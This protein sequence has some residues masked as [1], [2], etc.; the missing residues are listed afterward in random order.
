MTVDRRKSLFFCHL[1]SFTN[2]YTMKKIICFLSTIAIITSLHAQTN[3]P[4]TELIKQIQSELNQKKCFFA[5]AFKN[6]Q[7]GETVLWNEHETFHA[8]S[9]M[10]TPVMIEVFKQAA[11]GK[12]S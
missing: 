2:N 4:Q 9:T 6:I 11:S 12:I 5:I 7:T 8:A 1:T 3:M 10:K